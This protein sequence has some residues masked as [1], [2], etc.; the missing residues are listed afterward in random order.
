MSQPTCLAN[1]VFDLKVNKWCLDHKALPFGESYTLFIFDKPLTTSRINALFFARVHRS[2][3]TLRRA[4]RCCRLTVSSSSS[5]VDLTEIYSWCCCRNN[6]FSALRSYFEDIGENLDNG[7]IADSGL[8]QDF[9]RQGTPQ[10]CQEP[11]FLSDRCVLRYRKTYL[12]SA[13]II[14]K[15]CHLRTC[16]R[17]C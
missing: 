7:L 1:F 6:T 13:K 17:L 16:L 4:I 3:S 2:V 11:V 10:V 9:H 5:H 14:E 15:C 8:N 12:H